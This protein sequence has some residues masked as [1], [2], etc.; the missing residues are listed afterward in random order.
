MPTGGLNPENVA[1]YL[2]YDRILACGG[3]WIAPKKLIDADDFEQ[4]RILAEE[5]C[6]LVHSIRDQKED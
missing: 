1:D 2:K 5:A 3:S 6:R 4:I